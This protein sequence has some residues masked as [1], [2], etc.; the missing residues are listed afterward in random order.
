M[1]ECDNRRGT[2]ISRSLKGDKIAQV[3]RSTGG[4]NFVS[5]IDQSILYAFVGA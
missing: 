1:N 2:S 3:G 5:K 4:E